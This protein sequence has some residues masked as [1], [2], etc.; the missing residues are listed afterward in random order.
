MVR[1][2]QGFLEFAIAICNK[3]YEDR[4]HEPSNFLFSLVRFARAL[5]CQFIVNK[6]KQGVS[7][8]NN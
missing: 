6:T 3:K 1:S 8:S 7:G 5:F 2:I 4:D